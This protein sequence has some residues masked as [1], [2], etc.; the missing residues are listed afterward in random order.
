MTEAR[1]FHTQ[2][3]GKLLSAIAIG[4]RETFGWEVVL[5]GHEAKNHGGLPSPR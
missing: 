5:F 2:M 1:T 3:H 4:G